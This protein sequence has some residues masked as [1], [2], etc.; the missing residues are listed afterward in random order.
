MKL[1]KLQEVLG[2]KEIYEVS[3]HTKVV[4]MPAGT[5]PATELEQKMWKLLKDE[6]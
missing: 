4:V 6:N 5:R 2:I 3:E 1:E